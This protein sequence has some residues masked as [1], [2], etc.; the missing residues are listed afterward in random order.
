V[1][2]ATGQGD[3]ASDSLRVLLLNSAESARDLTR[4]I[5][6]DA[7]LLVRAC[8]L[9]QQASLD[10]RDFQPDLML[11]ELA[12]G[13][14][15]A[16]LATRLRQLPGLG[17]VATIVIGEDN[18]G[19]ER[20]R[21]ITAGADDFLASPV[22][23]SILID[24]IR[25]RVARANTQAL[26]IPMVVELP[27]RSG[28]LRRGDFL[29][30]LGGACRDVSEP[31]RVLIAVSVDQ[32][33]SLLE[34]LGQ[35]G[36][37]E[38]EQS[39][40][41]RFEGILQPGDAQ[42]LW[43]EFGFGIL[44]KRSTRQEVEDLAQAICVGAADK[45]FEIRGQEVRLTL[46]VG[47]A[48]PPS[49][50]DGDGPSRWF[51]S[52]YAARAIAN[53]LGGNRYDGVLTREYGNMP[54]ERVLIIRE[55]AKEAVLGENVL[56][57]FQPILPL[58]SD[59]AG[60]YLVDAKLRD[61]RAPLTGVKRKEYLKLA[62]SAGALTM[63]DRMSLFSAFEAIEEERALGRM[64]QLLVSIDLATLNEVQLFWL[65]AEV[66]RRKAHAEGIIIEF[67]ADAAFASRELPELVQRLEDMGMLIGISD[68]SGDLRRID[69]L[70]RLPAAF[71]RLPLSAINSVE[72][73]AFGK[74]M[75]PWRDSGRRLIADQ[76]VAFD[77]VSSLLKLKIDYVQGEALAAGAPRL[78]YDFKQL[79]S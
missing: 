75:R 34:S 21:V 3:A 30:Q 79:R 37:F 69:Q 29:S 39:I 46:S 66:G 53:R 57:E 25:A 52:A 63:I 76:V 20:F 23:K 59:L 2:S 19:S 64:T 1:V 50:S 67:D 14:D 13:E 16:E 45:P 41:T 60:L 7:G 24:A 48:L 4:G 62:E 18:D 31:W 12:I 35:A 6:E 40:A 32:S 47:V 51:A 68:D 26:S 22:S 44:A 15:G 43:M 8:E 77:S 38:L 11:A 28:Q 70:Q 71:L 5:L 27:K 49:D 54:A 72:S 78:D 10:A 17:G 56:I 74:L 36:A 33:K 58:P 55:W 9:A 73:E 61:Y 65:A 42:T